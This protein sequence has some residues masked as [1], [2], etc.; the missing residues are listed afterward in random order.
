MKKFNLV[1]ILIVLLTVFSFSVKAQNAPTIIVKGNVDENYFKRRVE[2]KAVIT[3]YSS[4]DEVKKLCKNI[5]TNGTIKKCEITGNDGN[6]NYDFV[7]VVNEPQEFS[8]YKGLAI[9]NNIL[10]VTVNGEKKLIADLK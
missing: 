6:G 5:A 9:K 8:F 3:G 10:Y 7:I 1:S 2:L 4:E